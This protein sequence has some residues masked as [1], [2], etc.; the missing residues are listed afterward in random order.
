MYVFFTFILNISTVV[1]VYISVIVRRPTHLS[2]LTVAEYPHSNKLQVHIV[3]AI[4]MLQK[5]CL[6]NFLYILTIMIMANN[7][8]TL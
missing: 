5:L 6:S 4:I 3:L 1:H 8:K 2:L 7:E